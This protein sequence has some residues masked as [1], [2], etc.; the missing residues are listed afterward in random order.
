VQAKNWLYIGDN[1][2]KKGEVLQVRLCIPEAAADIWKV[3]MHMAAMMPCGHFG[4]YKEGSSTRIT[5]L[6]PRFMTLLDPH[7][8]V[9]RLAQDVTEPFLRMLDE[10]TR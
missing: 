3:G 5:M 2:L 4:I 7:P 1:R 10:T 6:H 9:A 8:I